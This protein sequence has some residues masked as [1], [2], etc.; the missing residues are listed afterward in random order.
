MREE[1]LLQEPRTLAEMKE[2]GLIKVISR[3][4]YPINKVAHRSMRDLTVP[5]PP[6]G[7]VKPFK[8]IKAQKTVLIGGVEDDWLVIEAD[9]SVAV[10][11]GGSRTV[12]QSVCQPSKCYIKSRRHRAASLS[13][14]MSSS[15]ML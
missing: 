8:G 13:S 12:S 10:Y 11:R 1:G 3:E 7:T 14:P 2:N 9:E 5:E 6:P 15:G 4:S